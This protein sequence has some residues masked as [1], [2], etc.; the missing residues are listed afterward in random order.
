MMSK[1][2]KDR[3]IRAKELIFLLGYEFKKEVD[4]GG[5]FDSRILILYKRGERQKLR[6]FSLHYNLS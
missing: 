6:I 1:Y 5:H 3:Q 2:K 4:A